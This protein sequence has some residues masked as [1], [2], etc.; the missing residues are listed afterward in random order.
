[1]DPILVGLIGT[2]IGYASGHIHAKCSSSSCMYGLC[3]ISGVDM[4]VDKDAATNTNAVNIPI[5]NHN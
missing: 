2:A 1:M 3:T 4:E 5:N